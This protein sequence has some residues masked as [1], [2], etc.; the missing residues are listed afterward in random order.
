MKSHDTATERGRVSR[1]IHHN[2]TSRASLDSHV[3]L[4]Q[5][6]QAMTEEDQAVLVPYFMFGYTAE[7]VAEA[8]GLSKR[9]ATFR[10][11]AALKRTR[12]KL[13]VDS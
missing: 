13:G 3:L 10:I 4:E 8:L 9:G 6:L 1:D 5:A 7:A 11:H 2:V 12:A